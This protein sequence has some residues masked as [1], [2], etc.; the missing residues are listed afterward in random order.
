MDISE[1]TL[2]RPDSINGRSTG[3]D[4][5]SFAALQ[6]I[7]ND[8]VVDGNYLFWNIRTVVNPVR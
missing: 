8:V 2:D 3:A 1:L 6:E 7:Y 4:E 5:R